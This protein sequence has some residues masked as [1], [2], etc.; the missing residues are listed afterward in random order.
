MPDAGPPAVVAPT[1]FSLT[2]WIGLYGLA[3]FIALSFEIVW[4]RVLGVM[5]KSMSVTFGTLLAQY[6]LWLGLGSA[7]GSVAAAR[8]RR[9][10]AAFLWAQT[11]AALYAGL[12][13]AVFVR[14]LPEAE[15]LSGLYEYFA[16][17]DPVGHP[18]RRYVGLS[19]VVIGPATFLMG[20]SF[21]FLQRAVQTDL[22]YLG[23]R[24]GALLVANIAGST[25]GTMLTGWLLLATL[26][27]DLAFKLDDPEVLAFLTEQVF[28]FK[29]GINATTQEEIRQALLAGER[30][31]ES[32][33]QI[34]ARINALFESA[35]E[36][37]ALRIARTEILG[38]M[39]FG[40]LEGM[41]QSG[42][43]S[44]KQW[45]SAR[46]GQVRESHAAL[47]L[48]TDPA[49]GGRPVGLMSP[50]SNGLMY[51]GDQHGRPEEVVNCRCVVLEVL[52]R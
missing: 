34:A 9:P 33:T 7:V 47:D 1:S 31:G 18:F 23:R 22:A 6:L 11:G 43:V 17:Y 3:G 50:F 37:R 2:Q 46:D 36:V 32:V 35:N 45:L 10:A 52:T 42:I 41:A 28:K 15:S 13:L 5:L 40:Q 44:G 4:F 51:P 30:A 38:A 19:A 24:V 20:L 26:G 12:V 27:T 39:N 16:S 25:A 21:P 14:L 48:E 29:T 8:L 49:A